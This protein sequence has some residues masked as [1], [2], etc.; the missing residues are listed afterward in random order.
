MR[1]RSVGNGRVDEGSRNLGQGKPFSKVL[2]MYKIV[3]EQI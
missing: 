3:E 1:K 2:Y